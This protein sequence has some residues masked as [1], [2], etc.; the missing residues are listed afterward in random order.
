VCQQSY[1]VLGDNRDQRLD[2][3]VTPTSVPVDRTISGLQATD[4]LIASYSSN[5]LA[6]LVSQIPYW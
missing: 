4:S 5:S 3:R 2:S 1:L 6:Y